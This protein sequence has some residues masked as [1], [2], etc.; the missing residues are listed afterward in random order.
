MTRE[1][2]RFQAKARALR[3]LS[4]FFATR[5]VAR[6]AAHCAQVAA[7][8]AVAG[9]AGHLPPP[10]PEPPPAAKPAPPARPAV[11]LSGYSEAFKRGHAD[12]CSSAVPGAARVRDDKRS[13]TEPEYAQGWHDGYDVC[14]R[15]QKDT[16]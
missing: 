5:R 7:F 2:L 4:V 15:R 8:A 3:L 10:A 13:T 9:C 12:G 11:N 6:R 14:R 1:A 16:R